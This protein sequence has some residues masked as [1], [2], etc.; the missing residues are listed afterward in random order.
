MKKGP[1]SGAPSCGFCAR[2]TARG[3][4][5]YTAIARDVAGP[6]QYDAGRTRAL[7]TRDQ[8]IAE[9]QHPART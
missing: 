8:V 3:T 9:A 2:R 4:D 6:S 5:A 1:S 7:D